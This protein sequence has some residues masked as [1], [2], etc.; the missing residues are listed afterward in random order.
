M[1]LNGFM[2]R[3]EWKKKCDSLA[4]MHFDHKLHELQPK[5]QKAVINPASVHHSRTEKTKI[6]V[7]TEK[8]KKAW[9]EI[10]VTWSFH[11]DIYSNRVCIL[12]LD[13]NNL[14]DNR[15]GLQKMQQRSKLPCP[16]KILHQ[17]DRRFSPVSWQQLLIIIV[18][19]MCAKKQHK[20]RHN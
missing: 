3:R 16:S 7:H 1:N 13:F 20:K 5:S 9:K 4:F 14:T 17:T 18:N 8:I 19:V 12:Y 6:H 10:C 15:I 2:L 11:G